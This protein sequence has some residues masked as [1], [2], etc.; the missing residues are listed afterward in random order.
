MTANELI[1]LRIEKL[2]KEKDCTLDDVEKSGDISH[3][4]MRKLMNK[5]Y[6]SIN[7]VMIFKLAKGFQMEFREFMREGLFDEYDFYN[8]LIKKSRDNHSKI[9]LQKYYIEKLL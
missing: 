4:V 6:K 8:L 2:L 1:V 3:K 7:L 9:K 5:E